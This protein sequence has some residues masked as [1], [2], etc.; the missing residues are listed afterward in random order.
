MSTTST[1]TEIPGYVAGTW[2]IDPVHTDVS[3]SVRHIMVSKVRG[4][5]ATFEGEI[6]TGEN[7]LDSTV[8]AT[9]DLR[10][11]DTNNEQRDDHIRSTDFFDVETHPA[12]TFRSTGVSPDGDGFVV[13]GDLS[14]HGVTRRVPLHLEV[15]GF[16]QDPYGGTR[17]GFSATTE[18]NRKDFGIDTNIPLDGGGVVIG[19]KIQVSLEVEAI[20]QTPE[21]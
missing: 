9:V 21:A 16:G 20:L 1:R 3:F 19:D 14:L 11:I 7:P 17:A 12:M 15:N 5:F 18:L 10:S 13:E 2:T 8:N 4:R 6:V